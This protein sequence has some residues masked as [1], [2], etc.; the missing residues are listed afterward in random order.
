MKMTI[1]IPN[2]KAKTILGVYDWEKEQKREVVINLTVVVDASD[3]M[4]SDA[5]EDTLDYHI[6][7]QEIVEFLD[8]NSFSLLEAL[9]KAL[10]DL[11]L[12]HA[13]VEEVSL[14]IQKAGAIEHAPYVSVSANKKRH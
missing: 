13:I 2:L 3:A 12:A 1:S 10:I 7:S 8:A 14:E 6:L 4:E 11:V 9:A 5:I